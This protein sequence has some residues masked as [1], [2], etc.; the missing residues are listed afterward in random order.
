MPIMDI[1]AAIVRGIIS[2]R[3]SNLSSTSEIVSSYSGLEVWNHL[4]LALDPQE[5]QPPKP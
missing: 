2:V 4:K 1:L 5:L 3:D